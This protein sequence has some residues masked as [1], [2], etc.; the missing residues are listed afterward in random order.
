MFGNNQKIHDI[1]QNNFYLSARI[2]QIAKRSNNIEANQN[3]IKYNK[4]CD[5]CGENYTNAKIK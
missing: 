2:I 4:Y 1:D 3:K 5:S